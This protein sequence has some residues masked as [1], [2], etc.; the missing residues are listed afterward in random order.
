MYNIC[1]RK[2][3]EG[4]KKKKKEK[5]EKDVEFV[6]VEARGPRGAVAPHGR[7]P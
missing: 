1:R 3:V 4:R 7:V 2:F 5:K 6:H